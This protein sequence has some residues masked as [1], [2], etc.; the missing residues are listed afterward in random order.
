MD[1]RL[2]RSLSERR[3]FRTACSTHPA[4]WWRHCAESRGCTIAEQARKGTWRFY[5]NYAESGEH[6][7]ANT[8]SIKPLSSCIPPGRP[9]S[10]STRDHAMLPARRNRHTVATRGR[11]VRFI[12]NIVIRDANWRRGWWPEIELVAPETPR[13]MPHDPNLPV[14]RC[15][16]GLRF[17]QDHALEHV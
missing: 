2:S 4:F 3:T 14:A 5:T 16:S 13:A 17:Y 11:S 1:N 9:N 6:V 15:K 7:H 12:V 10:R 8:P